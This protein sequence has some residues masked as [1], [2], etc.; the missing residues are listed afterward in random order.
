MP[1]PDSGDAT[2]LPSA[3]GYAFVRPFGDRPVPT[4]GAHIAV[5][6]RKADPVVIERFARD[7]S[8]HS[9]DVVDFTRRARAVAAASLTHVVPIRE[10]VIDADAILLVSELVDGESLGSLWDLGR[11]RQLEMPLGI[12]LRVALDVL[13]GLAELHDLQDA[14]GEPLSIVHGEVSPDNV[15]VRTDGRA[16]LTH[17]CRVK[18]VALKVPSSVV[19]LPPELLLQEGDLD[20]RGDLYSVGAMLFD[21]LMGKPPFPK[22]KVSAVIRSLA[23]G[24]APRA[25]APAGERWA[26]PVAE[27]V[28]RAMSIDRQARYASA[29][30]MAEALKQSAGRNISTESQVAAWVAR[31]AGA[32]ILA[33]RNGLVAP[34]RPRTTSRRP[35]PDHGKPKRIEPRVKA[36]PPPSAGLR[37]MVAEVEEA[38]VP[39]VPEAK[40]ETPSPAPVFLQAPPVPGPAP[41]PVAADPSPVPEP[42]E[43][44]ID[45]VPERV[46]SS[47]SLEAEALAL[48]PVA[49]QPKR[50]T[51]LFVAAAAA[52]LLIIV[53]LIAISTRSTEVAAPAGTRAAAVSS[54][55]TGV[56]SLVPT[57]APAE[58]RAAPRTPFRDGPIEAGIDAQPAKTE[59]KPPPPRGRPRPSP[60]YDPMGI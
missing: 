58:V 41:L 48:E 20:A 23:S 47:G 46:E 42:D 36:P 40:Q 43:L 55:P 6:G 1:A 37:Q 50:R 9:D 52:A 35:P 5:K 8:I 18:W 30:E 51:W 24:N 12:A 16:V 21:A 13:S 25:E 14:K 34:G 31:V 59:P 3:K 2:A 44:D 32:R 22:G 49:Q 38:E 15:I 11:Q 53:V 39:A 7:K 17:V 27:V 28:A 57:E 19:Y 4:Y 56:V 54:P 45:V 10:V 60:T 29:R 26:R 33:R